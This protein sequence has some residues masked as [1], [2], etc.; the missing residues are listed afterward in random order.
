M[1]P[2][3]A[4]FSIEVIT[5]RSEVSQYPARPFDVSIVTALEPKAAR[6]ILGAFQVEALK[7]FLRF[8][9][10]HIRSRMRNL[11]HQETLARS[12]FIGDRKQPAQPI[13]ERSAVETRAVGFPK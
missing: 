8:N 11:D 5:E 10:I 13:V 2:P 1:M 6:V 9:T 4:S 3:C 12:E 7:E